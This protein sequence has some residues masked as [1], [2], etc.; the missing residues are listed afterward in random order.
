MV[1]KRRILVPAIL[2]VVA[3]ALCMPVVCAGSSD[4]STLGCDTIF[5]WTLPGSAIDGPEIIIYVIPIVVAVVVFA[6]ARFL[7]RRRDGAA[8]ATTSR[9]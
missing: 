5:G 3:F 2:A 4:D 1:A 9:S 6:V 8:D 7:L